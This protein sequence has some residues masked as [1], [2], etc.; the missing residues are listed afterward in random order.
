MSL[1]HCINHLNLQIS[2]PFLTKTKTAKLW[3]CL[4]VQISITW[5]LHV[6]HVRR[7][8]H[9]VGSQNRSPLLIAPWN[10]GV[11]FATGKQ[12]G[13]RR[14]V[15]WV[16]YFFQGAL[17]PDTS[18][19]SVLKAHGWVLQLSR[20]EKKGCSL[21]VSL[22]CARGIREGQMLHLWTVRQQIHTHLLL[23]LCPISMDLSIIFYNEKSSDRVAARKLF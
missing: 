3:T 19:M 2:Q 20:A 15:L 16:C 21:S 11:A 22:A 23:V 1:L 7:V 10:S 4:I 6:S 13:F 12:I 17:Q 5:D 14:Q 9:F 8:Y 18:S